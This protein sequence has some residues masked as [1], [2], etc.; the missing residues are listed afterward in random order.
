LGNKFEILHTV[1]SGGYGVGVTETWECLQGNIQYYGDYRYT[2]Y[3]YSNIDDT[4]TRTQTDRYGYSDTETE[5]T[6]SDTINCELITMCQVLLFAVSFIF[7]TT[8]NVIILI[9]IICNKDMR[10]V[11]NMFIINLATNDIIYLTVFLFRSLCE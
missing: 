9:I 8:S 2:G 3:S 4:N 1:R 7:G 5:H 10:T 11:P 6:Y